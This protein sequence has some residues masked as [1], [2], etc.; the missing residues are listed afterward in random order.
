MGKSL[1]V[2]PAG[3]NIAF[4]AGTGILPFMDLVGLIARQT[5]NITQFDSV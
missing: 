4:A 2:D 5:A 3:L 1:G